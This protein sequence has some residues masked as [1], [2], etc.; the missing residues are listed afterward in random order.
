[1]VVWEEES[2][3]LDRAFIPEWGVCKVVMVVVLVLRLLFLLDFLR[4][5]V[6]T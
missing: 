5:F 4:D 6:R 3:L 1:M 2:T